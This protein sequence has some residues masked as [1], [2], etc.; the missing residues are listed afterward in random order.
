MYQQ[1]EAFSIGYYVRCAYDD[2]LSSYYF[3]RDEGCIIWF[4]QQL[5]DLAH[6]VKNIVSAN[7]PMETLSKQQWAAY[8]SALSHLAETV[9]AGR[10]ASPRSLSSHQ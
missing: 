1:H 4:A 9:R 7:V 3:R 6:R 2:T 10:Y 8:C 5:N